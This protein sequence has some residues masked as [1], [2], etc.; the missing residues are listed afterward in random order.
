MPSR[1]TIGGKILSLAQVGANHSRAAARMGATLIMRLALTLLD[2]TQAA[3][4]IGYG[5]TQ[6]R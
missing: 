5:V 1:E 3:S 2:R 6:S 4:L